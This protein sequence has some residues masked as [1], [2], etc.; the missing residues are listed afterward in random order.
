V[1][2][3]QRYQRSDLRRA[4]ISLA[5]QIAFPHVARIKITRQSLTAAVV[6]KT[7]VRLCYASD[8][9]HFGPISVEDA[10]VGAKTRSR[11]Q[12]WPFRIRPGTLGLLVFVTKFIGFPLGFFHL[13]MKVRKPSR[14]PQGFSTDIHVTTCSEGEFGIEQLRISQF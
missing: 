11:H 8:W 10:D 1:I 14:N 4:S 5:R 13:W 12:R 2:W 9:W 6:S 3:F 7:T